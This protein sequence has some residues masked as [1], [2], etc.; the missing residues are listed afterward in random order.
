[1]PPRGKYNN[2]NNNRGRGRG[3]G[4]PGPANAPTG[5]GRGPRHPYPHLNAEIDVVIQQWGEPGASRASLRWRGLNLSQFSAWRGTELGIRI[6][7]MGHGRVGRP[8]RDLALGP[9]QEA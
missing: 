8:G 2:H 4:Q 3:R 7:G 6:E 1:M 9:L 5:T